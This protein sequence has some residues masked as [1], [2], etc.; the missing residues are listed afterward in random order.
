MR[1]A[2]ARA[3]RTLPRVI[4]DLAC[5]LE[6]AR[7]RVAP[8]PWHESF[9][10]PA[11]PSPADF[12]ARISIMDWQT[13]DGSF[14]LFHLLCGMPWSVWHVRLALPELIPSGTPT[15]GNNHVTPLC[16]ML[17]IMFDKTRSPH[18]LLRGLARRWTRWA[19]AAV[20]D[21]CRTWG[22]A[23]AETTLGGTL[24]SL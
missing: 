7:D 16:V 12:Q 24:A 23:F 17:G 14:C 6:R 10:E 5:A 1:H 20:L 2:R 4:H 22:G 9:A 21:I 19:G 18:N 3:L 11:L 13:P 8:V 15:T